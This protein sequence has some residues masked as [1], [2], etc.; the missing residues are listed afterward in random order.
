MYIRQVKTAKNSVCDENFRRLAHIGHCMPY[1]PRGTIH[2]DDA[3]VKRQ[4]QCYY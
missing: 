3:R 2:D 1:D 4:L